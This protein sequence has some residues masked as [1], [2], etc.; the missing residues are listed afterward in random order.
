MKRN[1]SPELFVTSQLPYDVPYVQEGH[2]I[3]EF[4]VGVWMLCQALKVPGGTPLRRRRRLRLE[5]EGQ[6][7]ERLR[8]LGPMNSR[9]PSF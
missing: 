4:Y 2:I 8:G 7:S 1:T 9:T 6:T 3:M 5:L